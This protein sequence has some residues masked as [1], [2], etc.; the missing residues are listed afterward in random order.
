MMGYQHY[1]V[2]DLLTD[3]SFQRY[4]SGSDAATV[5][6]WNRV[7][8][9]HPELEP[10][11]KEAVKWYELLSADQGNLQQQTGLLLQ[12][13]ENSN[14]SN[15]KTG[16]MYKIWRAAAVV[17]LVLAAGGYFLVYRNQKNAI[18]KTEPKQAPLQNDMAPGGNKAI[19]TL[20]DGSRVVLDTATNGTLAQQGSARVIKVNG[21]LAYNREGDVATS[22]VSYNTISTPRGGQYQVI[23]DD[24]TKVW[25]NAE[26]SLRF[27]TVFAGGERKVE[28]S[29]EGYFEVAHDAAMPFVVKRAGT[30][31]TVL[32]T[33]FN[34]MAYEDEPTLKVSLLQGSVKVSKDGKTQML[35]PGQQALIDGRSSKIFLAEEVD[36]DHVVSWKN[37]LF[38]FDN[39][40]LPVVMRQLSRWY[41]AEV[42]YDGVIPEGHYTGA[43]RRQANLSE[44]LKM[45]ELAG[46]VQF[47]IQ[48]KGIV[49]RKKDV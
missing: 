37:G 35:K 33:H 40:P 29:G 1:S 36:M 4:C 43:I 10:R 12:R 15:L 31:V 17:L 41:N 19:L 3:E 25:L 47:S 5:Q 20:A 32:G 42:N 26:S 34:I 14:K 9:E 16:P 7:L 2:E 23:L 6:F 30:E 38:D 44:V 22:D 45:L 13:I 8:Q 49:V 11:F 48:G 24:G 18:V 46:G 21:Q 27:P 28:L 39:D